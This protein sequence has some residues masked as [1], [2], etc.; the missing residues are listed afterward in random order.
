MAFQLSVVIYSSINLGKGDYN[1]IQEIIM[2]IRIMII[3]LL[4]CVISAAI[5]K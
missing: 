1:P 5:I 3:G 4:H 2:I